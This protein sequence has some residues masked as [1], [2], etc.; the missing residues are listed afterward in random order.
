MSGGGR[1]QARERHVPSIGFRNPKI[2][3]CNSLGSS[4]IGVADLVEVTLGMGLAV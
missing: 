1:Y 4:R 3:S 2:L